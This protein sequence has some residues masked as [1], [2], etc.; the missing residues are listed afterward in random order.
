MSTDEVFGEIEYP[1]KFDENSKIQP[2][3]PYSASKAAAEHFVISYGNTHKLPYT[4]I[5]C[6]NNYG[7]FQNVEKLI[8]KTITNLKLRKP[9]PVYGNGQQIRDWIYVY[10]TCVA[11]YQIY[12]KGKSFDRY[13]LGGDMEMSNIELI[14][15]LIHLTGAK[16]DLIQ[17]VAD[18]PGHDT[19]YSTNI[20]KV[21][22]ELKWMPKVP[23]ISG[24]KET[25]DWISEQT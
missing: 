3:N 18:R 23:L 14:Q 22:V 16:E 12:K 15:T 8:P 9:V 6:S 24:L 20:E 1:N 10:D 4:I 19:R 25:V 13:C 2:K 17:Y 21:K 7:P 5:N 11:L